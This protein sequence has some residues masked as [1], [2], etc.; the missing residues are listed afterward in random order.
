MS[1]STASQQLGKAILK[2]TRLPESVLQEADRIVAT[3]RGNDYGHPLD[4]YTRT[5]NMFNALTGHHLSA[6][7]GI[8]FMV[9]VKLSREQ[10]KAKRDNRV[11]AA[12]YIKCLDMVL[13]EKTR[14]Q[15]KA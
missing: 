11:D 12:G 9:C 4:D 5:V 10:H 2:K 3:D 15:T 13:S 1:E 14:R 6:E 8:L 7:E